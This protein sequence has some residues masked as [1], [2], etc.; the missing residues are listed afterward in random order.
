MVQKSA[1]RAANILDVPLAIGV[2]E[3]AMFPADH[4]R[5]EAHGSIGGF[6]GVGDR[7]AIALRVPTDANNTTLRR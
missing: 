5:L 3:F 1:R 4:F 6:G 2:H 7:N